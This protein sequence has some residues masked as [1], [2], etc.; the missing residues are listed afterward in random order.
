MKRRA[1][2]KASQ[3]VLTKRRCY[4]NKG[5]D[6]FF[7]SLLYCPLKQDADFL[8]FFFPSSEQIIKKFTVTKTKCIC[9]WNI[10]NMNCVDLGRWN[11][12]KICCRRTKIIFYWVICPNTAFSSLGGQAYESKKKYFSL[13]VEFF[14]IILT[15]NQWKKVFPIL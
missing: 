7:F 1:F 13:Y 11:R 6:F 8:I 2:S 3:A 15:I 5:I 14:L 12:N 10:I 9:L 4:R